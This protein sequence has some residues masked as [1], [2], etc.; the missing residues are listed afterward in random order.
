M[1][2]S[3]DARRILSEFLTASIPTNGIP[4]GIPFVGIDAVKNSDKILRASPENSIE[5]R[6]ELRRL[7]FL[8]VL[9]A[10]GRDHLGVIDSA[11]QKTDFPPV[12]ELVDAHE[13]PRQIDPRQP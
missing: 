4:R 10:H 1:E 11:L 13:R 9:R 2:F 3:G 8:R 7:D 5:S 12:L 6:T